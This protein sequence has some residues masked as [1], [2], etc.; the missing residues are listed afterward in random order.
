MVCRGT[1][2]SFIIPT[3]SRISTTCS[4]VT[5]S[6]ARISPN[7]IHTPLSFLT[8]FF[9]LFH[10]PLKKQKDVVNWMNY[11]PHKILQNKLNHKPIFFSGFPLL[12]KLPLC[13]SKIRFFTVSHASVHLFGWHFTSGIQGVKSPHL[14]V[15]LVLV[16]MASWD[17][18]WNAPISSGY[19]IK[20]LSIMAGNQKPY[21]HGTRFHFYQ[22]YKSI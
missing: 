17:P 5:E 12:V 13:T 4:D 21:Q 18:K 2:N 8:C 10:L 3:H 14:Q 20:T 19:Y 15:E 11:P 1:H 7:H 9:A 22:Q 6:H 16:L